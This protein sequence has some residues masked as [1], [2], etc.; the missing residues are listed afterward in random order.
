MTPLFSTHR[1]TGPTSASSSVIAY[2]RS[3]L[4]ILSLMLLGACSGAPDGFE[5]V[6]T[7]GSRDSSGCPALAGT[8]DLSGTPT[9]AALALPAQPNYYGLP[10]VLTFTQGSGGTEAWWVV[11][12][13]L[14]LSFAKKLSDD[15]PGR[16]VRWRE[17]VLTKKSPITDQMADINAYL[18]A[19]ADVGPPGPLN[20]RYTA[21]PCRNHWALVSD[22][23]G[24]GTIDGET[25]TMH[26]ETWLAHDKTGALLAKHLSYRV[27]AIPLPRALRRIR[28]ADYQR[29]EP[30][31]FEAATPLAPAELP[32]TTRAPTYRAMMCAQR[33][34]RITQ[35]S[36]RLI[37]RLSPAM[38]LARFVQQPEAPHEAK[39]E[40][41]AAVIDIDITGSDPHML[42][43]VDDWMR[44]EDGVERFD[45]LPVERRVIGP[46]LRQFR[47]V[48]R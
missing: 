30:L 4:L 47:V 1:A 3:T 12:R 27:T 32:P 28:I 35:F 34:L 11:P 44:N 18:A 39:G 7:A 19:F 6:P 48:F 17:Q 33:P 20:T 43:Y 46:H 41:A 24:P 31:A 8:F 15:E 14:L 26:H 16:Y 42:P 13:A 38:E 25:H 36:K 40:C 23:V 45:V 37:T 22:A 29:F 2:V 9:G 21:T 5:A 10:R